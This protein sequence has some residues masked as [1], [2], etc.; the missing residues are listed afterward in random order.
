MRLGCCAAVVCLLAAPVR[1]Q[2]TVPLAESLAGQAR[3]DYRSATL[4]Y[5]DGD[6]PGAL[7]KFRSAYERSGDPRLLWNVA[8]CEKNLRHYAR[9]LAIVQRYQ[10]DTAGRLGE[11]R[12]QEAEALVRAVRA[13]VSSVHLDVDQPGAS[14]FVDDERVGTTPLAEPL[15]VDLGTRRVR[16]ARRGFKEQIVRQD[17]AG[18]SEVTL[19]LTLTPAPR[20]GRLIIDAGGTGTI[21][22]DGRVVGEGRWEG[23]LPSGTHSV[24]VAAPGFRPHTAELVLGEGESRSL[25]VSLEAERTRGSP[26]LWWG[27]GLLV[28]GGLGT[29]AYFLFRPAGGAAIADGTLSPY[30]IQLP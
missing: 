6:Y 15:L 5:G 8:A 3:E 11:E 14:V 2:V 1:A 17:F 4:L 12:R 19:S 21:G 18:G 28:A 27:A 13:L 25:Y 20:E 7:V 10:R 29:G 24:R 23:S 22:V 26:L 9:V 16:I 30:K